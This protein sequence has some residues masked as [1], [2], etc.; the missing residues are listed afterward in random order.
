MTK[1][2]ELKA[3]LDA[4]YAALDA[5]YAAAADWDAAWDA[6]HEELEKQDDKT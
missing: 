1:L 6:Y 2:D 5:A 4:A 3:A